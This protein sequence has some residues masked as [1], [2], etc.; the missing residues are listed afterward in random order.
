MRFNDLLRTVLANMSEGTG[1]TVTR[2]RQCIDL[3]AQYDVSGASTANALDEGDRQAILDL[4]AQMRPHISLDQRIASVVELGSRLRS[5]GLVRLLSQDHPTLVAAMMAQ[6]HLSDADWAAIIPD[7]GPLARSVLRRRADLEPLAE[8]TLRQFGNVDMALTSLVPVEQ[9]FVDMVDDVA[10]AGAADSDTR[11]EADADE[12]SQIVRIVERIERF[13]EARTHRQDADTPADEI[14]AAQP[15]PVVATDLEAMDLIPTLPA[16]V[17]AFAF[18]TDVGGVLRLTSGAHRAASVGLS[19][20]AP[21]LD[22]RNG[23]DGTALGAFRRRAAFQ[24]ARFTIGEGALEGAWRMSAE[25]RFDR[26]SGRFLGYAGAARREYAHEGLVRTAAPEDGWSGLS[27]AST[28]QLI[29]ELRTP[30]N[31]IH[32]YAEMIDAQLL[33]P[34]SMAYRDM[35]QRI[36]VDA[37]SLLGTFEDLDLASR[38]ERGDYRSHSEHLDLGSMLSAIIAL[39]ARAGESPVQFSIAPYLPKVVGDRAQTDRMLTHLLRAGFSA[40]APEEALSLSLD[41]SAAGTALELRLQRP[42]AL[43]NLTADALL[44][45]GDL[46]DQ[47]L[48]EAPPL[49]L[50]FTLKLVRGIA[51]HLGGLFEIGPESFSLTLPVAAAADGDRENQG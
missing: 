8:A 48:R 9:P 37:R 21:A 49:G 32:G 36:L 33:G 6:V 1:A 14:S 24:N 15:E 42:E 26:A 31:A 17:N 22:S 19:I 23:A 27:A 29:H 4:V 11:D 46:V 38:I 7:L 41:V 2:W 12:Q 40:L 45:H 25:P 16:P 43:R 51:T 28:R 44:D 39:F 10:G 50:A 5:P 35:A 18:E 13:T 3:L 34:V 47:K 30:L 20:G